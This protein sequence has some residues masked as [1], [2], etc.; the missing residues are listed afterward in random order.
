[1]FV[2]RLL[3]LLF[4]LSLRDY[5]LSQIK[6]LDAEGMRFQYLQSIQDYEQE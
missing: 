1:M 4:L 6:A 3:I 2:H 5:Y